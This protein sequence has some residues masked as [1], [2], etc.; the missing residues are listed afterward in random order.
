MTEVEVSQGL[1]LPYAAQTL[2]GKGG[3]GLLLLLT[4]MACTSGFSADLMGVSTV[5]TYDIYRTYINRQATGGQLVKMSHLTVIVWTICVAIIATGITRTTI[6][7]NY[8]VTCMGVFTC[9]MVFPMVRFL[10]SLNLR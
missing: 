8:L 3:A 7:V 10:L 2:M 6:G 9:A 5:F 1:P 4:F